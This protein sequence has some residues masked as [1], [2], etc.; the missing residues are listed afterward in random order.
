MCYLFATKLAYYAIVVAIPVRPRST[1]RRAPFKAWLVLVATLSA[2]VAPHRAS[3]IRLLDMPLT[4]AGTACIDFAA[5]HFHVLGWAVTGV[6]LFIIEHMIAD[7][8]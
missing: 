1:V 6:S 5:F 4:V 7:N 8:E 3:L 2:L